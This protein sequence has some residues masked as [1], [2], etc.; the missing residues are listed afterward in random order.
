[1]LLLSRQVMSDSSWPHGLQHARLL[2][3]SPSPR[4]CPS[5]C[6]LP[7]WCHP[8]FLSSVALFSFWLQSFPTTG[9]FPMSGLFASGG[10]NVWA[11]A[12]AS[13]LPMSIQGWLPLWLTGLI[14]F[15]SKGLSRV[16]S[17]L[18]FKSIS[19]SV[20]CFL[21]GLALTTICEY[22]KDHNLDYTDLCG[23]N[24]VFAF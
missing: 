5:L 21:Y 11:S 1:M 23:Q 9:Y 8:A 3:P 15:L 10:Q 24:D 20:L 16:F 22:W 4:V 19:S 18:Q 6:P 13:V 17:A 2:S 14:S 7:W 12:S